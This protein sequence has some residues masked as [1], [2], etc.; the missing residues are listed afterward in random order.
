MSRLNS[1][2]EGGATAACRPS[3]DFAAAGYR[4]MEAPCFNAEQTTAAPVTVLGCLVVATPGVAQNGP[5]AAFGG[6]VSGFALGLAVS[7]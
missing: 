2:F 1:A 4:T 5:L 3:A 7:F 6:N